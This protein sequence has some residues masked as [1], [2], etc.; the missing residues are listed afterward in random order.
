[1]TWADT[2]NPQTRAVL[3]LVYA[4]LD[5]TQPQRV[6]ELRRLGDPDLVIKESDDSVEDADKRFLKASSSWPVDSFTITSI[7]DP[8]YP[9]L[10][11]EVREAPAVIFSQGELHPE[12]KGVSIVGSR[13]ASHEHLLAA[14]DS[15]Q[16]LTAAGFPVI[17]GLAKGIDTAV[18]QAALNAGGRTIAIMG[19]GI[20]TTYPKENEQLK[21]RIIRNNG[22]VFT[23]F[24]PFEQVKKFNFP[25]RDAVMSGYGLATVVIAAEENSGT[26]HQVQAA[27]KHGRSVIF[28][29]AVARDVP[30]ARELV[31]RNYAYVAESP[32]GVLDAVNRV[33]DNRRSALAL[34]K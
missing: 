33:F 25:M 24:A 16:I 13:S 12:E 31:T 14:A 30:W 34:F 11:S 32:S 26:R 3:R 21:A 20:E 27:V 5:L 22:L 1:M 17:S 2:L 7:L 28:A 23:Q 19:T 8:E 6:V 18:H 9:Y 4:Q 10:L 29:G 15:A